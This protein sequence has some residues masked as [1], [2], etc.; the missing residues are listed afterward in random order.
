VSAIETRTQEIPISSNLPS[1]DGPIY[2]DTFLPLL[3][4]PSDCGESGK[5][6]RLYSTNIIPRK[7]FEAHRPVA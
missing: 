7:L 5:D 3:L 2:P 1:C 4:D 6:G